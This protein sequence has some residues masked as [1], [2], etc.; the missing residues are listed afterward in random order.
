MVRRM[1]RRK[2]P[3]ITLVEGLVVDGNRKDCL[4][5]FA[6]RLGSRATSCAMRTRRSSH[7]VIV[8]RFIGRVY[9]REEMKPI[10]DPARESVSTLIGES[11]RG[12]IIWSFS[13]QA[14]H[15][16]RENDAIHKVVETVETCT[17]G[18][19]FGWAWFQLLYFQTSKGRFWLSETY[20]KALVRLGTDFY[21]FGP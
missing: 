9:I 15:G 4:V 8:E 16:G 10:I 17:I 19:P 1:F 3:E 14:R 2:R 12:R 11:Y 5:G 20:G 7:G 13:S 18:W 21:R 6:H